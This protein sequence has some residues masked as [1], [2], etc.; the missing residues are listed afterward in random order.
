MSELAKISRLFESPFDVGETSLD[1]NKIEAL[2]IDEAYQVQASLIESK[3][4]RGEKIAGYKV[5]CTSGAIRRQFGLSEPIVGHLMAPHIHQTEVNLDWSHYCQ[6]AVEPEMVVCIGE[7]FSVE[8]GEDY[9]IEERVDFVA[10][11]IE[12]HHYRFR[13][14]P[15]SIQE[16]IA[17]NG[18]HAG[19]IV[20]ERRSV[21]E[22]FDWG[23]KRFELSKNGR[24]IASGVGS[25]IMGG[26]MK[27]VKWLANTLLRRGSMLRAGDLVIPG[28][29]VELI[30]VDRGDKVSVN[31]DDLAPVRGT[32][33]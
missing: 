23:A 8:M 7:D 5:G 30:P 4:A 3:I 25:N 20:G 13:F 29:P 12:L 31:I 21:P 26:P 11:G 28:S 22:N 14:S 10:A 1:Q 24:S 16:L 32:F 18:I 15:P 6:L 2:S 19:L 17:S 33:V 27:S 9:S